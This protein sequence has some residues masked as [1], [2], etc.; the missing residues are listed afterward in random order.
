MNEATEM[1]R[2]WITEG[3]AFIFVDKLNVI[4]IILRAFKQ[5]SK[6]QVRIYRLL[7]TKYGKQIRAKQSKPRKIYKE[8]TAVIQVKDD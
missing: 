2:R 5:D 7:I 4:R 8:A 1:G 3:L 6:G